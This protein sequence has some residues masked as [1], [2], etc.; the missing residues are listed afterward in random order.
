MPDDKNK[1]T[2][3]FGGYDDTQDQT[4]M[5]EGPIQV[6]KTVDNI[7]LL[8][9]VDVS[10]YEQGSSLIVFVKNIND[11]EAATKGKIPYR[12]A[13]YKYNWDKSGWEYIVVG[14]HSHANMNILDQLGTINTDSMQIG[15]KKLISIE[16]IDPDQDNN[17][18]T[19][20]YKIT[21]DDV[22]TLPDVPS[23]VKGKDLYLTA[24]KNGNF[25]WTNSF[26]PAQTFK[27]FKVEITDDILISET[28]ILIPQK[29]LDEDNVYFNPELNDELL[30]FDSGVLVN[31]ISYKEETSGIHVTIQKDNNTFQLN[32]IL[33]VLVIRNGIAGLLDTIK[34]QYI[35][36]AEAIELLTN[37]TI[38]LNDYI[39]KDDLKKYAAQIDHTHSQYLR[40]GEYDIFDYRYAD[41]QHTHSQYTT[42]E[43][44]LSI[45]ADAAG[46]TGEIDT[47][48]IIETIVTSLENK[49]QELN[50]NYY[51]KTQI[52]SLIESAKQEVSNSDAIEVTFNGQTL[53]DYLKYLDSKQNEILH[54]DADTVELEADTVNL[55]EGESLGGYNNNEKI[56]KGTTL[57]QFIHTLITRE[58]VPTLTEPELSIEYYLTN[59]DAGSLSNLIFTLY[60]VQNDAGTLNKLILYIYNSEDESSLYR[61][62]ELINNEQ[63]EITNLPMNAFN[64]KNM[65]YHVILKASYD[66]GPEKISNKDIPYQIK[67][68]EIVKEFYLYNTRK[69]YCGTLPREIN[70]DEDLTVDDLYDAV[71]SSTNIFK[72]EI[73]ENNY[74]DNLTL[75][76]YPESKGQT[77][78]FAMPTSSKYKINKIIFVAQQFDMFNDFSHLQS[79]IPDVN[80][81]INNNINNLYDIYY[82]SLTQPIISG[83]NFILQFRKEG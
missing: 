82:Y 6:Q 34:N 8:Y 29:I 59:N 15:E 60:F 71:T 24:D 36:K 52:D 50:Q 48:Q 62:E 33:T 75:S 14:N 81:Q 26:V 64:D 21:F 58:K 11:P 3:S 76:F 79:N 7:N 70:E 20:D 16:K 39:T 9:T 18:R 10:Q 25:E 49:I 31:T 68:G 28:E 47:D 22:K 56:E 17:I 55:G 40:K 41:F 37:G 27:M 43:Q 66:N 57:T 38:K 51:S 12:G 83:M 44:V 74:K 69:L 42:R 72:F 77:I 80:D 73:T 35:T 5:F 4:I 19:E 65:C 2:I 32:E 13:F 45:I 61:E 30:I 54:V 63:T 78:I 67:A 23:D 46:E 53:T 1:V